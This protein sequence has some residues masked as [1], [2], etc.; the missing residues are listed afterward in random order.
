MKIFNNSDFEKVNNILK[1]SDILLWDK[2]IEIGEIITKYSPIDLK[3]FTHDNIDKIYLMVD[4]FR[5]LNVQY[6]KDKL[7][8]YYDILSKRLNIRQELIN[9]LDTVL[10]LLNVE[11]IIEAEKIFAYN[12][13]DNINKQISDIDDSINNTKEEISSL[14]A[15]MI[16]NL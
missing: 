5:S 6:D 13:L 11:V 4:T 9:L 10:D 2:I 7:E 14:E 12:L 1:S 3:N 15:K 8:A 16:Q